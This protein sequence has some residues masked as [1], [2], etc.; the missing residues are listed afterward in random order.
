MD[1]GLKYERCTQ[2]L[3]RFLRGLHDPD[4]VIG[5]SGGLDSSVVAALAVDALGATRVHGVL[6]PGPFSSDHSVED[7]W[8]LARRLGIDACQ[9]PITEPHKAFR[10]ALEPALGAPLE[11][12]AD[13]NAQARCRMV[14]LMALSNARGWIVLNTGNRSEALMGYSTLYGDTAGAFAPIGGLYKTDV[15]AL[16]RW[17]N[18]Q[19]SACGEVP[20]IPARVLTKPPSA[21]L[22]ANQSDEDSLGVSY[23]RLDR[24]LI[25]VFERG[26]GVE[27]ASAAAGLSV[28]HARFLV[29]RAQSFAF[30]RALEP[31]YPSDPFYV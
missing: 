8:E 25:D 14:V 28:A 20:P 21:E 30:K 6:M 27:E 11:G 29:E 31:P 10:T 24:L 2:A 3:A 7:A 5:L 22:S 26:R 16:A 13:E 9:V 18:A 17:R 4:V 19:A 15:F 12:L 1:A 23:E